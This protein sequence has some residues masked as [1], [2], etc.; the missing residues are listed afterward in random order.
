MAKRPRIN[1]D[2]RGVYN[3]RWAPDYWSDENGSVKAEGIRIQAWMN[4]L[5]DNSGELDTTL[6]DIYILCHSRGKEIG[7][8]DCYYKHYQP[9]A[10]ILIAPRRIW[11]PE[12]IEIMGSLWNI[13]EL[14][15]AL[16][17]KLVVEVVDQRPINKKIKIPF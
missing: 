6:K 4:I 10:G 8:Q 7:R 13:I 5:L 11:G 3:A 12:T 2:I 15:S 9:L 17:T 1:C 16:E 14:P